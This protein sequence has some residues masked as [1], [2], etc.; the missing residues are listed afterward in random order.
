MVEDGLKKIIDIQNLIG[1]K[2][3]ISLGDEAKPI[4]F[5]LRRPFVSRDRNL[6]KKPI[7]NVSFFTK[8]NFFL[9]AR[10]IKAF[11]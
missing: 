6:N 8:I 1:E 2:S 10:S 3:S 4:F 7:C 5:L 11:H 9:W